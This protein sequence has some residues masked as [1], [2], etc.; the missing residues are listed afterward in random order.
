MHVIIVGCGRAGTVLAARL[1]AVGD[2]VCAVDRDS[3]VQARLPAGFG[4][5]FVTGS[6][7][8]RPVLEAAG[9]ERADALVALT[10]SDGLNTVIA[11]V[12]RDVFR[13]PHVVGRLTGIE[14]VPA[15][16]ELGL[17]MVAS[18]QMTID[19]VHRLLRHR[20]LEPDYTFGNGETVLV[21][22]PVPDYL[23]GRPVTEFA[24]EGE[25][26]VV[27]ITRAGHS[28]IPGPGTTVCKGDRVSFV[29]TS[30]SLHRLESFLGGRWE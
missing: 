23:D 3:G 29:V 7:L 2:S 30:T 1:E 26:S 5:E 14:H 6:G 9:I 18:V 13:V 19:R 10:E 15:A 25:I 17:D 12:A 21:R 27:E 11:R 20:P 4:G 24:I 8:H 28:A 16:S 22:A